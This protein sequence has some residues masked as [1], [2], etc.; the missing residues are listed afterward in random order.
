MS[1]PGRLTAAG[2]VLWRDGRKGPEVLLVHRPGHDDWSL[3][4][5]KPD[6]GESSI[7]TAVR[8]VAEETGLRFTLGARLGHVV[9]EVKGRPKTVTYWAMR[10]HAEQAADPA[11]HDG[12]EID[13]LAWH[14]VDSARRILTYREDERI[15]QAFVER[16]RT[17]VSLI[18]VR[19][20]RAGERG[21]WPGPDDER[22]LDE[23]GRAQAA[24]LGRSLRA[25]E[26][27]EVRSAPLARCLQTAE[28]IADAAGVRLSSD[29]WSADEALQKNPRK[30]IR[31]L[32]SLATGASS[33]VV[34]VS[35]GD[36]IKGVLDQL[37]GRAAGA[38]PRRKGSAWVFCGRDGELAAA[39]YYPSLL[40]QNPAT[41]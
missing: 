21:D 36:L 18:L 32:I 38:H 30:T 15:V 20:G 5:G 41:S 26:P 11:P 6:P 31:H 12:D 40:P 27:A 28:P 4:K 24:A 39:D 35:Q 33:P 25:F 23:Q 29:P 13:D 34:V 37:L 16:G 7:D 1:Q 22:P 14:S 8:E 3:P 17:P 9:Y 10:L 19:H 2:G